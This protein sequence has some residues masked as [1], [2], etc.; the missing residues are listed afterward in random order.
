MAIHGK[1][2]P[3]LACRGV[4]RKAAARLRTSFAG[5]VFALGNTPGEDWKKARGFFQSL[6][7]QRVATMKVGILSD[8][9]GDAGSTTKAIA[10]LKKESVNIVVHCGDIGSDAILNELAGAFG[11]AG[12]PVH[13]VLGNVD[14]P[15]LLQ[16]PVST[17][18]RIASS[19]AEVECG[20]KRLAVIHGHDLQVMKDA[21]VSGR[22]DFIFTGHTHIPSDKKLGATRVINPGALY[23]ANPHTVAVLDL[24]SGDLKSI[25]V[26]D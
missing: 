13:A 12:I 17:G 16:F 7:N 10:L 26:T 15:N 24:D 19:K 21:I 14:R 4:A 11:L 8:T 18:I 2:L 5:A 1:S 25:V 6:E 20:G 23:Q 22:Y 3:R 9:H